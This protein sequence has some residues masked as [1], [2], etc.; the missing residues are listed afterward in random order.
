MGFRG[1]ALST[2][3]RVSKIEML[4]REKKS[5]FRF[6]LEAISGE[7]QLIEK[8]GTQI[9]VEGLFFNTPG[10]KQFLKSEKIKKMKNYN[11][12]KYNF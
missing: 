4:N 5:D 3:S 9:L 2:I 11:E 10:R 12:L 8:V 7:N 6:K 1:E